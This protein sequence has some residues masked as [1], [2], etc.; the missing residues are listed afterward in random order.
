MLRKYKP[1]RAC[2]PLH[3]AKKFKV[4]WKTS[5][6]SSLCRCDVRNCCALPGCRPWPFLFTAAHADDWRALEKA[7]AKLE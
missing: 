4:L 7:G 3:N 1:G 6:S 5:Q 2:N